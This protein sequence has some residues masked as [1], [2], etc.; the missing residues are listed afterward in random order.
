MKN[1]AVVTAKKIVM[2]Y[3]KIV[4]VNNFCNF[5]IP[6]VIVNSVAAIASNTI[7]VVLMVC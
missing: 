7:D 6:I 1:I 4:G 5:I 3:V 2:M